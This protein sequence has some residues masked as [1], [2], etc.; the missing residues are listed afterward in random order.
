MNTI[1]VQGVTFQVSTEHDGDAGSPWDRECGHGP[2]RRLMYAELKKRPGERALSVSARGYSLLYDF[3]EA[4][5]I[6][7]RDGW[8]LSLE[9]KAKLA[10][11]LDRSPTPREVCVEA[12][13]L[14]FER[15]RAWTNDEWSYVIVLV[16][17]PNGETASLGGVESD[18]DDDDDDAYIEQT[19][20]ELAEEL[21]PAVIEEREREAA[22]AAMPARLALALAALTRGPDAGESCVCLTNRSASC[23]HSDARPVLAEF[24]G[25]LE[26]AGALT[27]LEA[28]ALAAIKGATI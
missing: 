6:A 17:A 16:T 22:H 9:D 10:E 4:V 8:G 1:T 28:Q 21:A 7:R 14:D 13:R 11:R 26:S 25:M 5:K 3:A 24:A 2:V 20:R 19:A 15:M 23:H 12:A 27:G 18:D